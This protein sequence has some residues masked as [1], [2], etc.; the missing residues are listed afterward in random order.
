MNT[1]A[2]NT[3]ETKS[4]V[5][6]NSV[7]QQQGSKKARFQFND[8]RP[9]TIAQRKL[10]VMANNSP[11]T[12]QTAQLQAMANHYQKP[13]QKKA[14]NTG[15]P[16]NL[17]SGIENLSGYSMDDVKVHYNSDRP[18]QLNAHAYAQGTNI[19]L[20]SGQEKHLPHEAWHI[21]Q[22]KQGRVK[23][24]IQLKNKIALNDDAGLEKEADLMGAKAMQLK[25]KDNDNS[26]VADAIVQKKSVGQQ[27]FGFVDN[28][29]E[30]LAQ[31]KLQKIANSHASQLVQPIQRVELFHGTTIAYADDI[32][33]AIDPSQ[34]KGEFGAGF[35]TVFDEDQAKHISMYYWDE[36]EKWEDGAEGVAVVKTDIDDGNWTELISEEGIESDEGEQVKS[37]YKSKENWYR[38]RLDP[39]DDE[40][41]IT[42]PDYE[43]AVSV[44]DWDYAE[45]DDKELEMENAVEIGP[46]KD[47]QTPYIQVVFSNKI[48]GWL[49]DNS[50][51]EM[52]WSEEHDG[53]IGDYEDVEDDAY[54]G[55]GSLQFEVGGEEAIA[56]FKKEADTPGSKMAKISKYFGGY[57]DDNVPEEVTA[58][59]KE[60]FGYEEEDHGGI[61]YRY[62]S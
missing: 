19:H 12:K 40:A 56:M 61:L 53:A 48:A 37:V 5:A 58:W 32:V 44:G 10:H 43:G 7:F 25:H 27:P 34:G 9:E 49:N 42:L 21:V 30:T 8:N 38:D 11:Q 26:T 51:R 13:V 2:D 46:I 45:G 57:Q 1:H 41:S 22:Q 6:K 16:D 35:Y 52:T 20:A 14:N 29:P 18:A 55:L 62:I 33:A 60:K 3:Q 15:L 23:P 59:L 4:H 36:E 17:K 24:T 28:R 47:P 54:A 50:E 31:K 39:D